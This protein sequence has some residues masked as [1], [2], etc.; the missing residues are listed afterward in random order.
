MTTQY[1]IRGVGLHYA[2]NPTYK[3]EMGYVPEM[4]QHT[5]E[6]LRE[7]DEKRPQVLL[8]PEPDNSF[9]P[10]AVMMR[11]GGR[12]IGYVE[13]NDVSTCY[14]LLRNSGKKFLTGTIS[15]VEVEERGKL[16]LTLEAEEGLDKTDDPWQECVWPEWGD[17]RPLLPAKEVWLARS[18]AEFMI[19]EVLCPCADDATAGELEH[20]L[21]V[22][23]ESSLYDI[24]EDT[25]RTCSRYIHRFAGHDNPRLRHWAE[26]LNR[27]RIAFYGMKR[28]AI[29][30]A[31]WESL[32]KSEAME[33]LWN[34][35]QYHV[36]YH[37]RQGLR[38]IDDYLRCLPDQLY[39]LI[40]Q[41]D[42]FFKSLFYR[43]GP[44]RVLWGIF[45]ALLI[46]NR[47][48]SELGIC[49]RPL[50]EDSVEYGDVA[51]P[52]TTDDPEVPCA[53]PE[54]LCTP[55]AE[56]LLGKFRMAGMLDHR[57]QP[58][59]LSNAE[60]GLLAKFL[61]DE[62]GIEKPWKVFGEGWDMNSETLRRAY[63]KALDQAKSLAFQD[64]LKNIL[65]RP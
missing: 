1:S 52:M 47:T 41:P 10:H 31:W 15:K 35:W 48:C 27:Y 61:S 42:R 56:E 58:V 38:V 21:N 34:K 25:F 2:A 54:V 45:T 60:R 44:R 51:A 62:L 19:D 23:M 16:Y 14:K 20:Y 18:E 28:E 11:A 12:R 43:K 37:P 63:N 24:S 40:G 5:L 9:D 50:A 55:Q 26:K 4:E 13:R 22:W 8:I 29:R 49:I 30:M 46:R 53:L 59:S 17:Q 7:L 57:A 39:S 3:K 65:N 6:I 36:S 33:V 32:K 64:Q